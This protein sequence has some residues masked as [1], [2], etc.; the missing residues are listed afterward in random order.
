MSYT[1][2]DLFC[3]AGG[4]SRGLT[5]AGFSLTLA[6]NHWKVAID[7]HS[8]NFPHA[9][10]LCSDIN[11][12]D[13][14]SLPRTDVL[15]ASP[16][17][18]EASPA[19]GRSGKRT[20]PAFQGDL[21]A[22]LG[23][24]AQ[25]GF[26]RTRA[27]FWDVIRAA[28]VHRYLAILV[29][30]VPDVAERW[31]LFDVWL[32]AMARLGYRWQL[33]SVNAAHVHAPDNPPAPQWR[34][35]LYVVLTRDGVPIPD[36]TPH[37]AAWC[38]HCR[39]SVDGVQTWCQAARN[40]PLRVGRY[41]RDPQSS[42]GQYWYTCPSCIR[43]V[44]PYVLPAASAI[45]WTDLGTPIPQL[46][47]PLAANTVARIELGLSRYTGGATAGQPFMVNA[48]HDDARVYLPAN[49]P[50]SSR[51][52]KIGDGICVPPLLV[53]PGGTWGGPATGVVG[54]PM[55]T[56]LANAK[57]HEALAVPEAFIAVLRNHAD[58]D[59]ITAPLATLAAGGHHHALIVP[60]YTSGTATDTAAPIPTVTS[61]DRFAMVSA[62]T[63]VD[64]CRFRMV[65]P[66]ESL[67]AQR[68][69]DDYVVTGGVGEQ[70]MQA[71]N[72]V[73]VNVAQW[74]GAQTI[75]ALDRTTR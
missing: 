55:L 2:T 35:R 61:R 5:R 9:E 33:V 42:Y 19:G 8:A 29:E 43:R 15:W 14:R 56:R 68:F 49:A 6:A 28:E 65:K 22:E 12:L 10:H 31:E 7:T 71:G 4:A 46:G 75:A 40:R 74:I 57:G 20:R 67:R 18:T 41:R 69:D 11:N 24:V 52:T 16:I 59:P 66:R 32:S 51:T 21:L 54:E 30:N 1:L 44:E 47:R 50:L 45:D 37:P 3:G 13:M 58:A 53:S 34:D 60:Y 38:A 39:T 73:A 26:E 63:H 36:V 27:T 70:T 64:D 62:P 25:A 48:N 23:Y 72:A 17:C